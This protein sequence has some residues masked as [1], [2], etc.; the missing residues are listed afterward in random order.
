MREQ[1]SLL[2][3]HL[4]AFDSEGQNK[5]SDPDR[6]R[7]TRFSFF[8]SS[9]SFLSGFHSRQVSG[10]RATHTLATVSTFLHLL[11]LELTAICTTKVEKQLDV[12]ELLLLL[13]LVSFFFSTVSLHLD[14]YEH[15][16][17][18]L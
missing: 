15:I 12:N 7:L 6:N 2:V 9:A 10:I 5:S 13:Y 1:P 16:S 3:S 17:G 18:K 4:F 14:P 11:Y 8:S